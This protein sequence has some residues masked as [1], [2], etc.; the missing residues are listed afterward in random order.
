MAVV[1][2]NLCCIVSDEHNDVYAWYASDATN[3][4][5][6][7]ISPGCKYFIDSFLL[8]PHRKSAYLI[9]TIALYVG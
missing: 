2:S 9:I 8:L 6:C 7:A 4:A 3:G 1:R 5:G